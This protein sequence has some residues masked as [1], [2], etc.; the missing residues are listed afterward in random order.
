MVRLHDKHAVTIG[1][2][3]PG[4]LRFEAECRKGWLRT[5]EQMTVLGE[6]REERTFDLAHNR[7]ECGQP[8]VDFVNG[9]SKLVEAVRLMCPTSLAALQ[10]IGWVVVQ[11]SGGGIVPATR[12]PVSG[13]EA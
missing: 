1:A 11:S 12:P 6:V 3:A 7:W 2:V 4:T 8:G 10:L 9:V 13:K 5:Y